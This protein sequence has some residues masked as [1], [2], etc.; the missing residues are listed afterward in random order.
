MTERDALDMQIRA[1]ADVPIDAVKAALMGDS[2]PNGD[3]RPLY[4]QRLLTH[5]LEKRDAE[6]AHVLA[7]LMDDNPELDRQLY[8]ILNDH[9]YIQPDEVYAFVRAHLNE[10][11]NPRWLPRLKTAAVAALRVAITEGDADTIINWLTL[12]AREPANFELADVLHAGILAAAGRAHQD[13]NLGRQLIAL[14]AKRA[15][16]ALD[17]LLNDK[18]LME[19]LPDNSG[20]VFRTFDGDAL[21]TLQNR[22]QETFTVALARAANARAG[23][24]FTPETIVKLWDI[25]TGAQP[26]NPALPPQYQANAVIQELV[27]HGFTFLTPEAL[28]TLMR[29]IINSRR[30]DLLLKML[31]NPDAAKLLLDG[32]IRALETSERSV[33]DRLELVGRMVTAGILTPQGAADTYLKMIADK[34]WNRDML[35]LMQQVA[36]LLQQHPNLNID[37]DNLWKLLNV[38]TD[39]K[40]ELIARTISKRLLAASENLE[41]EQLTENMRRLNTELAWS[42]AARATLETWWRN[43][44]RTLHLN[45]LQK[46]DKALDGR[47]SLEDERNILQTLIALRRMIGG[48]KLEE[49]ADEIHR[50]YTLLEAIA[51]SFDPNAKRTLSFDP[52]IVQNELSNR[53]DQITPEQ[54]QI[55]ANDLRELAGLIANM[56]D[57]RTKANLMRRGDDLDRDLMSGEQPPHSAVDAMKWLAGFWGGTQEDDEEEE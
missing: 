41:E 40:D 44:I 43:F 39:V 17:I 15:P 54:R 19:V 33:N 7:R 8:H 55:L 51:E 1:G 20:R 5:A 28:Q 9:L 26:A 23:Q 56:G 49:F 29:L 47:R 13:G 2:P 34:D 16:S 18:E 32:A 37:D 4:A 24:M 53:E 31:Q 14:A 27:E 46:L 22:G 57:N 11:I 12:I 36:R 21:A 6:A 35:P 45:R 38:A 30:D 42:E 52:V 25:Y 10:R 50:A 3:L 48:R